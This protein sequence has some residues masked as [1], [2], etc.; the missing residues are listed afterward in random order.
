MTVYKF[1]TREDQQA[2]ST[3]I[4]VF[5]RTQTG[6][7]RELMLKCIRKILE[8]YRLT[9]FKFADYEVKVSEHPRLSVVVARQMHQ[10][11]YCPGCS[12]PLFAPESRIRILSI[13]EEGARHMVSYG[14]RCGQIFARREKI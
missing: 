6:Y 13:L 3:A 5:L 1:P 12:E 4:E 8:K 10:E 11:K 9:H 7:T 2:I 14:C